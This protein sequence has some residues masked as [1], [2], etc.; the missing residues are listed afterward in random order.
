MSLDDKRRERYW[1]ARVNRD[2]IAP[3]MPSEPQMLIWREC[4]RYR[5]GRFVVELSE[6]SR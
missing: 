4:E 2:T 5:S 1:P 3:D 6:A